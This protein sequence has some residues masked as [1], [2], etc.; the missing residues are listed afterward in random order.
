MQK[1]KLIL[2]YDGTHYSGFQKQPNALSIQE[3][4]ENVLFQVT[5]ERVSLVGSGRTD[6]GVHA[7]SQTAHI[8]LTKPLSS[9]S[10]FM[11][12]LNSLL[13]RDIRILEISPA[14]VHFHARFGAKQ[15]TYH[16]HF[17]TSRIHHPFNRNYCTYL[18]VPVSIEK[19]RDALPHFSGK[20]NFRS[21]ANECQKGS[22]KTSPIKTLEPIQLTETSPNHFTLIFTANGFLYKM[23]RNITGTLFAI[24]Q[25]K[26]KSTD[27]DAI[28]AKEDRRFTPMSAPPQ[29]L[30]LVN[31][32]YQL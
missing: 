28:F 24:G 32:L 16:Y 4:L 15:K 8:D 3:V 6:A 26:L 10:K 23:V 5:Q 22:A 27:I 29:G 31:V 1:Y 17:S 25:G 20:K 18:K 11:H 14:P 13:P 12:S 2:S 7:L 21:F 19:M 9:P 30:F